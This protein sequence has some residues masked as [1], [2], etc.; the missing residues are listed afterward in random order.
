MVVQGSSSRLKLAGRLAYL[1]MASGSLHLT[2]QTR[3]LVVE[4]YSSSV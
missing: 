1:Y 2:V 4:D 3:G